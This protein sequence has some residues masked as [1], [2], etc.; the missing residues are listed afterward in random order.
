[1]FCGCRTAAHSFRGT[2]PPPAIPHAHDQVEMEGTEQSGRVGGSD[3]WHPSLECGQ[4]ADFRSGDCCP[5]AGFCAHDSTQSWLLLHAAP[6]AE[7]MQCD[8]PLCASLPTYTFS[9]RSRML[10]LIYS[11][12][13][14]AKGGRRSGWRARRSRLLCSCSGRAGGFNFLSCGREGLQRCMMLQSGCRLACAL[15]GVWR[16]LFLGGRARAEA[17]GQHS[18]R[19]HTKSERF[20][21]R[22]M[23]VV[24]VEAQ[25]STL[26]THM[27][28]CQ[29]L[30][31]A[32]I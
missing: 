14:G 13:C 25:A 21:W 24:R 32:R 12:I 5:Y 26:T 16:A 20:N 28:Q 27:T 7:C 4:C 10:N 17:A 6:C 18:D 15:F 11:Q 22:A 8:R 3:L 19:V 1:M 31:N 29:T 9:R 30:K 2:P 23:C